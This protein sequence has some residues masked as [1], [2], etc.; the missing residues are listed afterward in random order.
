MI[1]PKIEEL[2]EDLYI[3]Q[4]ENAHR[5]FT[6]PTPEVLA[7]AQQEGLI[8][9]EKGLPRL[10]VAGEKMGRNIVRRHRLAECLLHDVLGITIDKIH[11][12]A[13]E[14]EHILR[15]GIDDRICT[16]MGHPRVCPHGKPI[17]TGACCEESIRNDTH[18][19]RP[20]CDGN[21]GQEGTVVYLSTR[22]DREVQ[23][24]MA[25][26]ILPGAEIRLTRLFPSY[27]FE[28]GYSQFTVDH[29]LA[30]KIYVH[31]RS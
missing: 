12:D 26:G 13:C 25:I 5:S 28:V 22:D 3:R 18:E 27:V 2:L 15:H 20:L 7:E 4:M 30:E 19:V 9:Q 24:L 10:T 11:N 14:F 29:T 8:G 1:N 21:A 16:L 17:P 6:T 31:W 23:K